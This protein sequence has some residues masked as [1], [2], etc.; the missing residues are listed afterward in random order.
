[1]E[2]NMNRTHKVTE[3]RY[4]RESKY[5]GPL[6]TGTTDGVNWMIIN[7]GTHPNIYL[8]VEGTKYEGMN[9][10]NIPLGVHGGLTFNGKSDR[11]PDGYWI[12]WDY[13]HYDDYN[14]RLPKCC[15]DGH[16]W[17]TDELIKE[18][19]QAAKK[20]S[21]LLKAD[22]R[23]VIIKKISD[24]IMEEIRLDGKTTVY[25]NLGNKEE[26]YTLIE[27]SYK[28]NVPLA[29]VCQEQKFDTLLQAKGMEYRLN[30]MRYNISKCFKAI[31][32]GWTNT[33]P[34]VILCYPNT[35]KVDL[36]WFEKSDSNTLWTE[37][38]NTLGAAVDYIVNHYGELEYQRWLTVNSGQ[39]TN[40]K[41]LSISDWLL[42]RP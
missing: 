30:M 41:V 20:F 12:G 29:P 31:G 14:P 21:E 19:K 6:A 42:R 5:V 16:K 9:Y 8:D 27:K 25:D 28:L 18:A 36:Y 33:E 38:F 11:H 37:R 34:A 35:D 23:P 32:F 17:T 22:N 7:F 40:K 10:D 2:K 15:S 26:M 3:M 1:M 13:A 4:L 24:T 39:S